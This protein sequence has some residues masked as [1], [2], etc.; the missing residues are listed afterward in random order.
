LQLRRK[1]RHRRW[2]HKSYC[3][4]AMSRLLLWLLR[5]LIIMSLDSD[6]NLSWRVLLLLP[7]CVWRLEFNV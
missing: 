3:C 5:W 6:S 7:R 1:S 2:C 4:L